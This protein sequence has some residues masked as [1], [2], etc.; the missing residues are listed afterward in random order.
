MKGIDAKEEL[1]FIAKRYCF[2]VP[3]VIE[4]SLRVAKT[5]GTFKKQNVISHKT[6][7]Y[8]SVSHHDFFCAISRGGHSSKPFQFSVVFYGVK[9]YSVYGAEPLFIRTK[10]I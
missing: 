3:T 9:L 4:F 2:L 10:M 1:S 7:L 6:R 8:P 5:V